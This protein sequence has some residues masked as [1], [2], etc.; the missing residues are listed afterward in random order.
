MQ[1]QRWNGNI[2][3]C[4]DAFWSK[5]FWKVIF[6]VPLSLSYTAL[7]DL[8]CAWEHSQGNTLAVGSEPQNKYSFLKENLRYSTH[9]THAHIQTQTPQPTTRTSNTTLYISP[10]C[11]G[12]KILILDKYKKIKALLFPYITDPSA[13]NKIHTC[14]HTL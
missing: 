11:Q 13:Y 5:I 12:E 1:A 2:K 3:H 7:L 10:G 9:D 6:L 14:T 4:G 8:L